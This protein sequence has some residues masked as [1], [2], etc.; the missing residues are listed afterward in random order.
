MRTTTRIQMLTGSMKLMWIMTRAAIG[1][2]VHS[3]EDVILSANLFVLNLSK[4]TKL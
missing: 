4:L 2:N 1:F 3:L